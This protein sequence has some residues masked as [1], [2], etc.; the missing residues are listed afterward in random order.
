MTLK[1]KNTRTLPV[2]W[3]GR[4]TRR[5]A[6][7]PRQ[8]PPDTNAAEDSSALAAHGTRRAAGPRVCCIS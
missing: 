6:G 3:R 5:P 7:P 8:Q 4:A 1:A 2:S